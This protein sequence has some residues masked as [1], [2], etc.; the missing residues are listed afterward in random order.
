MPA[1]AV[2]GQAR[3]LPARPDARPTLHSGMPITLHR[4]P[5]CLALAL[6]IGVTAP[7]RAQTSRSDSLQLTVRVRTGGGPLAEARVTVGAARTMTNAVGVARLRLPAGRVALHVA[8][9][10]Y[11]PDSLWLT[12]QPGRDTSVVVDLEESITNLASIVVT[13]T[14]GASRIEEA[15]TRVEVLAGEDVAEKTEMRPSDATGFLSEMGG[16]R[17]Q[18]TAASTGAAGVRLQGLRPRY[19]LMLSDGLP[20]VGSGSGLDILQLP[21]VDLRQVEVIK[22]PATALYGLA[23]LGGT[24]N[25]I[26]KRPNADRPERDLLVQQSSQRGTNAFGWYSQAL[27]STWGITAMGGAH[28]QSRR[29]RDADGWAE[30]P[31]FT[32]VEA[33]P[34]LFYD[35]KHGSSLLVTVGGMHEDRDAGFMPGR[36]APDGTAYTEAYG[37]TRGDVGAI[38]HTLLGGTLLQLRATVSRETQEKRFGLAAERT[39]RDARFLEASLNRTVHGHDLLIG[40]AGQRDENHVREAP[41]LDYAWNTWSAFAQDVWRVAPRLAVT[42]SA[43]ADDHSR[44]GTLVSPRLSA[45]YTIRQGL[46]ARANYSSGRSAPSPYVEATQAVGV[47]RVVGFAGL[48]PERAR[49]ASADLTG[50]AGPFELSLS[51]FDTRITDAVESEGTQGAIVVRNADAP[52]TARGAEA[53]ATYNVQNFFATALY[54]FTDGHESV[55]GSTAV[56]ETPYFPRHT[57]GLDLTWENAES[58]TWIALEGFYSG[59]QQTEDDPFIGRTKP[60]TVVGLLVAQQ[61]GGIRVFL[62]AENLTDVRQTDVARIVLP[63]RATDGRWTTAPWG[64]LEGRVISLGVRW[65]AQ[66]KPHGIG[67]TP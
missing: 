52:V 39:Q 9:I 51:A 22:G 2:P 23:A 10:G 16:V 66:G 56:R 57:A 15:P 43:R 3:A 5:L 46:T 37:T 4:S 35:S 47:R 38:G 42:G 63:S 30:M 54:T 33:R 11:T 24:I 55:F 28:T 36:L 14:R 41:G 20:L 8:R 58:G 12:L 18:R 25:L 32:R 62:S 13:S 59:A 61:F 40:A 45:L 53:F 21:P 17:I 7:V 49:Y 29:D 67:A 34:R 6:L 50:T 60:Y 1:A 27:S 65:S 64:Q 48:R 19:T 44:Y 26:S 31:G